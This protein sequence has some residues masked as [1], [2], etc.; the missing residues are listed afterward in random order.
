MKPASRCYPSTTECCSKQNLIGYY[1]TSSLP[2]TPA[3]QAHYVY[4]GSDTMD[5]VPVHRFLWD[6]ANE[7]SDQIWVSDDGVPY[8]YTRIV[9]QSDGDFIY[10]QTLTNYK[11]GDPAASNFAPPE[12]ALTCSSW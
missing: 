1:F 4:Q 5:G 7:G 8:R 12:P 3:T 2:V 9:S 11:A 6:M 10:D